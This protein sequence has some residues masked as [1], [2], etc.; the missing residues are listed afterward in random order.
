[1]AVLNSFRQLAVFYLFSLMDNMMLL[2]GTL[3]VSGTPCQKDLFSANPL[4]DI[5]VI[6]SPRFTCGFKT[7]DEFTGFFNNTIINTGIEARGNFTDS[8][9]LTH[10]YSTVDTTDAILKK[11]G[12]K[13]N[14][15]DG[16]FLKYMGTVRIL[17]R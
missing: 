10:F 11:I 8:G 6:F 1:M 16:S 5:H 14:D 4:L 12:Q 17:S 7:Q 9:D 2:V 3:V 15:A 13:C